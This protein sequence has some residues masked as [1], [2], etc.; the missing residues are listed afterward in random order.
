M[1]QRHYYAKVIYTTLSLPWFISEAWDNLMHFRWTKGP[2]FAPNGP[3][4]LHND[5]CCRGSRFFRSFQSGAN[6]ITYTQAVLAISKEPNPTKYQ[7][8][9]G[10]NDFYFGMPAF[11]FPMANIQMVGKSQGP[12]YKGARAGRLVDA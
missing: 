7:K 5:L 2:S 12:M 8:T 6:I 1:Q 10:L 4:R 9:L 11:G 3:S